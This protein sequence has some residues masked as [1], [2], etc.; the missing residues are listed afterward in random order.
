KDSFNRNYLILGPWF[1]G[2]WSRPK[3]DSLGKIA[4]ENNTAEYFQELQKKWFD[5]WL[6]DKGDGKFDEA[7]CFQTGSNQWKAYSSWPPKEATIMKLY[8]GPNNTCSFTKPLSASGEISYISDPAKPVPYRAQ[9]IEATY[10]LGSR[11]RS[12]ERR[13][14]KEWR[15]EGEAC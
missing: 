5:Y 13:V 14:G 8:A 10:G 6:R 3:A 4:F 7:T 1:H 12:E 9:P 15:S 11:W 2:Q